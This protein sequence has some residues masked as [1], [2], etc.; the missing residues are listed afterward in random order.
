[1]EF[2][3]G[4]STSRC[5]P[6]DSSARIERPSKRASG[7]P[8]DTATTWPAS[9]IRGRSGCPRRPACRSPS[10]VDR[11]RRLSP[12]PITSNRRDDSPGGGG[13]LAIYD[14]PDP[15]VR[16]FLL[17][18][19]A[20]CSIVGD[21]FLNIGWSEIFETSS[22]HDIVKRIKGGLMI[23][24]PSPA[25]ATNHATIVYRIIARILSSVV[26]DRHS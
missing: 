17:H 18:R 4:R 12:E 23:T 15:E 9:D 2:T 26:D 3:H 21:T 8:A 13:S 22:P 1:M 24:P 5:S 14:P 10:L 25:P 11:Q 20:G 19:I 7:S 6:S 16:Q